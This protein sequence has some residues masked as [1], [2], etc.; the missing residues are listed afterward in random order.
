MESGG[1]SV[2]SAS[3]VLGGGMASTLLGWKVAVVVMVAAAVE[4]GVVAGGLGVGRSAG[5][6]MISGGGKGKEARNG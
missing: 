4:L 5:S 6:V 1:R 2:V 3:A